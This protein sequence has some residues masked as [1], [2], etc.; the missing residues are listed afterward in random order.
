M[1]CVIPQGYVP[2]LNVYETQRAI[3]FIKTSFQKNLG[4]ALNLKRVSAPL[5]VEAVSYTHLTL[6]TKA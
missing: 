2:R 3:E 6:P 5:F 1:N 4:S